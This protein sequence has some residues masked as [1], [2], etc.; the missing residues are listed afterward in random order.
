MARNLTGSVAAAFMSAGRGHTLAGW[1]RPSQKGEE[2]FRIIAA[3]A[4]GKRR[5]YQQISGPAGGQRLGGTSWPNRS[6][7]ALAYEAAERRKRDESACRTIHSSFACSTE[8]KW[9]CAACTFVNTTAHPQCAACE[10]EQQ[11]W[12]WHWRCSKCTMQNGIDFDMCTM[13]QAP[14]DIIDLT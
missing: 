2:S 3:N 12:K 14:K 13:C 6:V 4:A 1:T 9:T 8:E 11:L 5:K 10:T 7:R